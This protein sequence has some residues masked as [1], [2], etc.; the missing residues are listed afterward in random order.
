[1]LRSLFQRS[2]W[3]ASGKAL[4]VVCSRYRPGLRFTIGLRLKP[5]GRLTSRNVSGRPSLAVHG[6]ESILWGRQPAR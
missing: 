2:I 4:Q 1:M 6:F 3:S 5:I